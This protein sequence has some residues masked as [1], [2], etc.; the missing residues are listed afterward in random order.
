MLVSQHRD[1][2]WLT[3][4]AE[5]LGFNYVRGST[6]RGGTKAIR[7]LKKRSKTRSIGITPD[8]PRGPRRKMAPG[9]VF[10]ASLLKMPIVPVGFGYQRPWRLNT[11]DKFAVPKPFSR[12]RIVMGPKIRIE[13]RMD[14]EKIDDI[15]LQI[16]K[17]TTDLTTVAENWADSGECLLNESAADFKRESRKLMFHRKGGVEPQGKDSGGIEFPRLRKAA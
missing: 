10:M 9:P 1:A 17:L 11:W 12:A 7:E 14:R 15:C 3:Q 16:E 2:D 8:G 13:P 4:S 6:T 5:Y